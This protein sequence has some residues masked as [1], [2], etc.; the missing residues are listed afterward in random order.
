MRRYSMLLPLI[1]SLIASACAEKP[2]DDDEVFETA[3]VRVVCDAKSYLYLNGTEVD[4]DD[5]LLQGGFKF[6]NPNAAKSCGCGA[7]FST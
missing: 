6:N 3:G 2:A 1:I 5:S 7:S 4:Y